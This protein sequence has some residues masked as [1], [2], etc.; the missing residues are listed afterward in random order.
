MS[1]SKRNKVSEAGRSW[2]QETK[3]PFSDEKIF[4][5]WAEIL[6]LSDATARSLPLVEFARVHITKRKSD[7]QLPTE[8]LLELQDGSETIEAASLVN[9]P[10]TFAANIQ[11]NHTNAGCTWSAMSPLKSVGEMP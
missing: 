8:H 1:P 9:S 11:T 6:T 7:P 5:Y 4:R 10:P 2:R 3:R